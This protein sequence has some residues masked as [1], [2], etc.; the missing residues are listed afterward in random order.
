ML[1]AENFQVV[2]PGNREGILQGDPSQHRAAYY[3]TYPPPPRNVVT[4]KSAGKFVQ[5][6][7]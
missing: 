1:Q 7:S 3:V 4:K 2:L 6:F 5:T